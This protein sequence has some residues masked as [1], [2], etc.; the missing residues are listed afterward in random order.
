MLSSIQHAAPLDKFVKIKDYISKL[1]VQNAKC[2]IEE[3][4]KIKYLN[5]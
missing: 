5:F 3:Y 2:K 4:F 1:K